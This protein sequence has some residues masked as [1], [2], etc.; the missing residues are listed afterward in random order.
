MKIEEISIVDELKTREDFEPF[1]QRAKPKEDFENHQIYLA[2]FPEYNQDVFLL[3]DDQEVMAYAIVENKNGDWWLLEL[4][5]AEPHRDTGLVTLLLIYIV[6]R[7]KKKVFMDKEVT[8]K[9]AGMIEHLIS[10]GRLTGSIVDLVKN[11]VIDYN[12]D[13]PD[14]LAIPMYDKSVEGVDRPLLSKEEAK[15]FTW[16]LESKSARRGI[17]M[18]YV[19]S[20]PEVEEK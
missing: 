13:D 12:P 6:K 8:G 7:A 19:R 4:W 10:N 20:G 5:V 14:H 3:I 15:N 1:L 9:S 2:D 16:L 18:P 17:L 11:K